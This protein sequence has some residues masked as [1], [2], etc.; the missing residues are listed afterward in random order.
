MRPVLLDLFCGAGGA[1][2]GYSQAGFDVVGVDIAPQ[3]RYPFAFIQADVT[4]LSLAFVRMFHAVHASPPCQAYTQLQDRWYGVHRAK[5][6][7]LIVPTRKMLR[8][9]GLPYVI[10]NVPFAPLLNPITLCGT[11]FRLGAKGAQLR[12]HRMFECPWWFASGPLPCRHTGLAVHVN[13]STGG[14]SLRDGL[15][16]SNVATRRN[17]MG[18]SWMTNKELV[19]AIPPAFTKYVGEQLREV[20]ACTR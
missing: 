4:K 14:R 3:P 18:I 5:H 8:R 13:G 15:T 11:M 7:D 17:A 12:R 10:E 1:A 6:P 20:V 2:M 19:E 9:A 16:L